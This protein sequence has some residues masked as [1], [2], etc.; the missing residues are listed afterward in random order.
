MRYLILSSL[1][2]LGGCARPGSSIE[3]RSALLHKK[4]LQIAFVPMQNRLETSFSQDASSSFSQAILNRL[5]QKNH[6][7]PLSELDSIA[8]AQ[9]AKIPFLVSTHLIQ[10]EEITTHPTELAI[11]IYLQII[12]LRSGSAQVLY[13][14]VVTH[15]TLLPKP[16]SK[17]LPLSWNDPSFRTSPIGLAYSKVS[18]EIA[19]YIEDYIF[20]A[21]QGE[22]Q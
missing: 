9:Q 13:Q 6:L 20:H 12:D 4:Q 10:H 5:E 3:D 14:E 8:K 11:G 16:L 17:D 19:G 21:L 18:R 22:H 1:L 15:N 2:L 7:I